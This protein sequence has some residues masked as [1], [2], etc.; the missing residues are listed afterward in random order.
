MK[1]ESSTIAVNSAREYE[2]VEFTKAKSKNEIWVPADPDNKKD[3][4]EE[5]DNLS[6]F[7]NATKKLLADDGSPMQ[8]G[9]ASFFSYNKKS[10]KSSSGSVLSTGK[11]EEGSFSL[12]DMEDYKIMLLRKMIELLTR[13][14]KGGFCYKGLTERSQQ[15]L[16][17]LSLNFEVPAE[18]SG[19]Q[20]APAPGMWVR[21]VYAEHFLSEEESTTF[22]SVGIAKTQDGREL[23]FGIDLEMSRS[24][25]EY[26]GIK[27][28]EQVV[29]S[30][31]LVINLDNNPVS[32]S[33]QKFCFDIDSDGKDDQ[34]SY[35]SKG[36][37]YLALDKNE[38]GKI[39]NGK[40]LFG[41]KTGNGFAE[42]SA[43]DTDKNGW[44][45]ESDEI[46]NKLKIWIKAEDGTDQLLSLKA[47]DIGA[48]YLDS[49]KTDFLLKSAES[50]QVNGQI[51]RTGL[52][53]KEST[54]EAQTAQQI[55][56]SI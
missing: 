27:W 42:L 29:M 40:E 44:I 2:S 16:K 4:I 47:A 23:S 7:L 46:Y 19:T 49:A 24:F 53:L 15:T 9:S 11:S 1:I 36:R 45:D 26:T 43:Y 35:L 52:Y 22:S 38:D 41:A 32:L 20:A 39:N 34:I 6:K 25:M 33:D 14:S 48:I 30:D 13:D 3:Q 54:G 8:S 21:N 12:M 5:E 10:E 31:P 37:G 51:R 28:S 50:G 56:V 17:S 55:D 18:L